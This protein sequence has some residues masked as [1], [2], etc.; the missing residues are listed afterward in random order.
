[1]KFLHIKAQE[2]DGILTIT[3]NR[4]KALNALNMLMV[5]E[6]REALENYHRVWPNTRAIIITGAGDK[7][8]AAGA[9][10]KE[11]EHLDVQRAMELSRNGHALMQLIENAHIP[12]IAAVNGYAL[13]GGC[14]LAMACHFR[15]ASENAKFGQ[16]EANLGLIPGFGGTQRLPMLIGKGR[17]L[18][19][20]LTGEMISAQEAHQMGLVNHVTPSKSLLP[21]TRS[22]AQKIMEKGPLAVKYIIRCVNAY[23]NPNENGMELE[24]SHFAH[25]LPTAQARE[26]IR[27]FLEKRKPNFHALTDDQ[28][29]ENTT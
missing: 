11:F 28:P 19:L 1:M 2:E 16:P 23:Y 25:L 26:G 9:D 18:E 24:I 12:I 29:T 6:L 14:E 27:A 3:L 20:L 15:I 22:I 8:F 17:A 5:N 13:G 7:A 21:F 10:I 4:P